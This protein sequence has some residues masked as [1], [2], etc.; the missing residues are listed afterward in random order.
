MSFMVITN[1][2][3]KISQHLLIFMTVNNYIPNAEMGLGG[4][5]KQNIDHITR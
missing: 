2:Y 5:P 3:Y 1:Y 4:V